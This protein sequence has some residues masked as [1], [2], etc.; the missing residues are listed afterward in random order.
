MYLVP[1]VVGSFGQI[2]ASPGP[3]RI[4]FPSLNVFNV[5]SKTLVIRNGYRLAIILVGTHFVQAMILAKLG[6]L[7]PLI[8]QLLQDV[9]LSSGASAAIS[10]VWR[11]MRRAAGLQMLLYSYATKYV[12]KSGVDTL[13]FHGSA[14]GSKSKNS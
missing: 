2:K 11:T 12:N 3:Q 6:S 5:A 8:D 9:H 7:R 1:E 4:H 13:D 10:A 14:K